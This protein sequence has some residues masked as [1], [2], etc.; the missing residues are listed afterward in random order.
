M[1]VVEDSDG[2]IWV[3]SMEGVF[4]YDGYH[5]KAY[6]HVPQNPNS[7]PQGPART[8]FVSEQGELWVGTFSGLARY[9]PETDDFQVYDSNNSLIRN[10]EI[11]SIDEDS[12]GD[13]L[14]ADVSN[15][16]RV[17]QNSGELSLLDN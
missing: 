8:M 14:V 4:R 3:G 7:I 2:Y 9:R 10:N 16:Y 6:K 1:S 17:E 13:I 5:F 12:S 15:I 11:R